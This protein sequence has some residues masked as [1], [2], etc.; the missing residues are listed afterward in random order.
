MD[1][2]DEGEEREVSGQQ[3]K[4]KGVELEEA[5]CMEAWNLLSMFHPKIR[6]GH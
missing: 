1:S 3:S 6:V 2:E 4:V 5:S